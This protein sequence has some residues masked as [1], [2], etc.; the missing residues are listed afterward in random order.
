M[1]VTLSQT[2]SLI[3]NRVLMVRWAIQHANRELSDNIK[4]IANVDFVTRF[5]SKSPTKKISS[6]NYIIENLGVNG[7]GHT[8]VM[9]QNILV[10][11]T[12]LSRSIIHLIFAKNYL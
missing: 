12:Y 9:W 4:L 10:A 7:E 1:P 3:R 11:H 8:N 5:L 2:T 6:G